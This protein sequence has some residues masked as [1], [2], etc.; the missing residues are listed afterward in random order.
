MVKINMGCGLRNFGTDWI[1]IDGASY[2]HIEHRS[3]TNLEM[4]SDTVDLIY[5]SHVL[6]YFNRQEG[7]TLLA[8]W[9][10][11]LKPDGIL[12]LAVPDFAA[13]TRL[14]Q[15]KKIRLENVLGP[16]YGAMQMG[17]ETIYHKTTYDLENLSMFLTQNGFY[18]I[19]K[20]NWRE[21][22]HSQFDDHSQAYFPH[23]DKENGTLISLNV[24][25][26]K[27]P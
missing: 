10:R 4:N 22:D 17:T 26:K 15:E 1:H 14:Y 19:M 18:E 9:R 5:A 7:C 21:T 20:Y 23:M 13:L 8:E 2:K 24:E 11:V 12:R 3:I 16:L 25:G 27:I 6:E